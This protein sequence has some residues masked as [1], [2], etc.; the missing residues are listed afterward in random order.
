MRLKF[1]QLKRVHQQIIEECSGCYLR[2]PWM[3]WPELGCRLRAIDSLVLRIMLS[4]V[5]ALHSLSVNFEERRFRQSVCFTAEK[6]LSRQKTWKKL[7]QKVK[8]EYLIEFYFLS[9]RKPYC[10]QIAKNVTRVNVEAL[11]WSLNVWFR[12]GQRTNGFHFHCVFR[13]SSDNQAFELF[14]H[15]TTN[16][17]KNDLENHEYIVDNVFF[18]RNFVEMG[19]GRL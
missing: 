7:S 6:L 17:K 13:N 16:F 2:A 5:G 10:K 1:C 12:C 15:T 3:L 11:A 9:K 14:N 8:K 18:G 4:N 19:K